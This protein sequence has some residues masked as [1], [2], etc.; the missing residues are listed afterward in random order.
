MRHLPYNATPLT[1][2]MST[3]N[4]L[5]CDIYCKRDDLFERDRG[6]SKARMLQYILAD[7]SPLSHDVVLTAGGPL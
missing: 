1:H 5:E 7:V 2:M 3:S 4:V 6:G